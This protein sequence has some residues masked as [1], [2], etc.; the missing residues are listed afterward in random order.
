MR[1]AI[2][3]FAALA[4]IHC[5]PPDVEVPTGNDNPTSDTPQGQTSDLPPP[6]VENVPK[7][8]P[9]TRLALRGTATNAVRVYVEGLG[10]PVPKEVNP[11][12]NEY[13]VQ[14][15]LVTSPAHYTLTVYSQS[16]DGKLSKKT[17]VE[18]DRTKDAPAPADAKLCNGE[19]A[20]D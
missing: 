18:V 19:P 6:T 2:A 7:S 10:N 12:R 1:S 14:V 4:A 20:Q 9:Y 8:Y 15:D 13:C 3:L 11:L 17:T 16:G 5:G